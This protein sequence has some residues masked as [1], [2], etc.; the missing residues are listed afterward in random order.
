MRREQAVFENA[1]FDVRVMGCEE[2]QQT[3]PDQLQGRRTSTT[4]LW[5]RPSYPIKTRIH[6]YENPP[7]HPRG[8]KYKG[9][10][11]LSPEFAQME[12][13]KNTPRSIPRPLHHVS[14]LHYRELRLLLHGILIQTYESELEAGR[15]IDPASLTYMHVRLGIETV[16]HLGLIDNLRVM[17]RM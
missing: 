11:T 15:E 17:A 16:P 12:P 1:H 14:R 9:Q 10:R 4:G 6:R 2:H 13:P 7:Q 3:S 5:D 8:F